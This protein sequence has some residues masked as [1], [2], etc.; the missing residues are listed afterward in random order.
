MSPLQVASGDSAWSCSELD[1]AN[2]RLSFIGQRL[3]SRTCNSYRRKGSRYLATN[4]RDLRVRNTFFMEHLDGFSSAGISSFGSLSTSLKSNAFTKSATNRLR[5]WKMSANNSVSCELLNNSLLLTGL[6][7]GPSV[8]RSD[9]P[10][11]QYKANRQARMRE[12]ICSSKSNESA[13]TGSKTWL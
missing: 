7:V 13:L 5:T 9:R 6:S 4:R 12:A 2:W 11:S 3:L 1:I 10:V 8:C